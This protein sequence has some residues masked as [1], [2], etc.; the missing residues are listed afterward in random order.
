MC[1]PYLSACTAKD[2]NDG[3]EKVELACCN[4]ATPSTSVPLMNVQKMNLPFWY[5][6]AAARIATARE[7]M[8]TACHHTGT[9]LST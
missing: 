2:A 7:A 9:P 8:L 6:E 3:N 4:H 1:A 5:F